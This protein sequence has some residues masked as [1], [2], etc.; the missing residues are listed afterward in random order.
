MTAPPQIA[1]LDAIKTIKMRNHNARS[2]NRE[3][4]HALLDHTGTNRGALLIARTT[5]Q[6]NAFWQTCFSGSGLRQFSRDAC[7]LFHWRQT[8]T[9]DAAE[10]QDA[11]A[12][13]Q[14]ANIHHAI[15][16]E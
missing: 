16:S 10:L 7:R 13:I 6:R 9:I 14:R 5:A 15:Q 1:A 4:S 12:P 8:I 2:A 3:F 11:I